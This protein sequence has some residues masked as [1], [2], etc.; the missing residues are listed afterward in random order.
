M[1]EPNFFIVGFPRCGTTAMH[2][3]L[4]GHPNIF[5]SEPKE[6]NFLAEDL[7]EKV[8]R[9]IDSWDAYGRLFQDAAKN[10][11][12]VGESSVLYVYSDAALRNI[13]EHYPGAKVLVMLRNPIELARSLHSLRVFGFTEDVSD[14]EKAWKLQ[15]EWEKVGARDRQFYRLYRKRAML[16]GH[17]ERLLDLFPRE[18]VKFVAFDDFCADTMQVYE[19]V[20]SFLGV[21]SDGRVEFPRINE[22]RAPRNRAVERIIR[23]PVLSP[24]KAALKLLG[25][26]VYGRLRKV[27]YANAPSAKR[28][29]LRPEFCRQLA[30]EFR[31]DVE[32]L[33]RLVGRDFSR[34]LDAKSL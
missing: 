5:M 3:Y 18:Q 26:N 12:V 22:N 1:S 2:E 14:F 28:A 13:R 27:R 7:P 30:E 17:V 31:P 9:T 15:D 8:V 32:K 10:H 25:D 11:H 29:P 21:P 6:P 34:W 24:L 4:K 33:S 19:D 16:G 20:L 23:S